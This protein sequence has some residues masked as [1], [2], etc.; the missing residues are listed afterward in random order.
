MDLVRSGDPEALGLLFERYSRLVLSVALRILQDHAEAEDLRQDVF[1]YL[2][3][4]ACMFDPTR[5]SVASWVLQVS[6]SKS[7]N[8]RHRRAFGP[9][10]ARVGIDLAQ[11]LADPETDPEQVTERLSA[12]RIVRLALV[13]LTRAQR[14]TLRLYFFEGCS[15]REICRKRNESL[16]NT[17]HHFYRGMSAL[18]SRLKPSDRSVL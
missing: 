3:R 2:L 11:H 9:W 8:R 16:G 7:L 1:V 4:R 18:R 17:R 13:E 10:A 6:Y 14:E 5:G 12:G 15:L